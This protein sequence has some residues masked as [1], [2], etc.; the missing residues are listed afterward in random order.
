MTV[1][2]ILV[3]IDFAGCAYDVVATAAVLAGGLQAEVVLLYVVQL[4]AGVGAETVVH[5]HGSERA[6]T[7][8]D[9]LRDD[10]RAHIEPLAE[11]FADHGV[12]VS[13]VLRRGDVVEGILKTANDVDADVI[14]MGTHGRKGLHRFILGSVAE[15]VI[16]RAEIPVTTVRA[17]DPGSHAGFDAAQLQVQGESLG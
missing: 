1:R 17:K 8:L 3:P 15:Q 2:R 13:H 7:A 10:A 4:P 9:L 11:V 5:P 16:R 6:Q 12:P 14:I